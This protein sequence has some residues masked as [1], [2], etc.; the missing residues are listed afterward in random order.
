MTPSPLKGNMTPSPLKGEGWGEGLIILVIFTLKKFRLIGAR[1]RIK[2]VIQIL[3]NLLPQ[4]QSPYELQHL[5]TY[6]D[7]L[8]TLNPES[9]NFCFTAEEIERLKQF[10]A[11]LAQWDTT[12]IP[13][14]RQPFPEPEYRKMVKVLME[15]RNLLSDKI[16]A[17]IRETS[18]IVLERD[19]TERQPLVWP[20]EIV[21]VLDHL[22]SP[23]NVGAIVRTMECVNLHRLI[24]IGYTPR[25]DSRQVQRSGMGCEAVMQAEYIQD[26]VAALKTL[27]QQGFKIYVLETIVP[28]CSVFQLNPS[29]LREHKIAL[30]VGN[31]EF[32][33][34]ETIIA[35]A[36]QLLHI[37]TFGQK[38][39][40]NV[41][42]A[43][44]IAVYQFWS[45]LAG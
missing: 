2:K 35:L 18:L 30:V 29:W 14:L 20:T 45:A 22:R 13:A 40:L 38:N 10:R 44:S 37:P 33:V 5:P 26:G 41:S 1:A 8:V 3:E 17:P 6:L 11:Q 27:Q 15:L 36:D 42:I 28:S 12:N 43:F 4:F 34:D 31:E 16:Q 23:Y 25:L 32:G 39:S 7:Y 24:S 9:Q 21:V 19:A